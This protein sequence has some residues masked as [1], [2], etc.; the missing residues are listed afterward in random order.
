[1]PIGVCRRLCA[2]V[3]VCGHLWASA[4]IRFLNNDN[5]DLFWGVLWAF[6]GRLWA[7]CGR[8]WASVG[9]CG[10]LWASVGVCGRLWASFSMT[11]NQEQTPISL[12][13]LSKKSCVPLFYKEML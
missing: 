4:Q 2:S 1:M 6:Y 10:R 3:G 7:F 5:Y 13:L 11:Q 8:L 12:T 9:A